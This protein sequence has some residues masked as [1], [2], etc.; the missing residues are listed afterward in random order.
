METSRSDLVGRYIGE[1]A[2]KTREVLESALGGV[3]FIDEAYTLYAG[4][5][6]YK[7]YGI[8]AIDEIMKFMEDHRQDI[9]LIFAGYTHSMEKF[10]ES[11]EGLRS[12]IPNTFVFEDYTQEELVRIGL[13]D[14]HGQKYKIDEKAYAGLVYKKHS[15]S[16]DNSNGRW[17]RNLNEK[18]VRKMAVRVARNPDADLALI[19]R[20]DIEAV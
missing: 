2:V 4:D 14:L 6:S 10:L 19:T 9:V 13:E 8:E 17:V 11:N 16:A 1:T 3:L 20:E 12:R 7:D 18:L 15:E 5:A